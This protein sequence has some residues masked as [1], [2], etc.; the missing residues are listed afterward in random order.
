MD[1]RDCDCAGRGLWMTETVIALVEV[2]GWRRL[3]LR[4]SRFVDDGD[5]DCAG[6]GLWITET[7]IVLVE[8]CGWRRLWLHWSRFVDDGDCD[9]AGRG[10]WMTESV[11]MMETPEHANSFEDVLNFRITYL[12][13]FT[14]TYLILY[15]GKVLIVSNLMTGKGGSLLQFF[16]ASCLSALEC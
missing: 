10:L 11:R 4:W 6:R 9:C 14:F 12:A 7:V 8:V 5:C 2:C 15:S 1:D 3:W 16:A 13:N